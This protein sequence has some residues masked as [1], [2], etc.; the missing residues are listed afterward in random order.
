MPIKTYK[1]ED[2]RRSRR[3]GGYPWTHLYKQPFDEQVDS[4]R[5]KMNALRK[6]KSSSTVERSEGVQ[7]FDVT[8]NGEGEGRMDSLQIVTEPEDISARNSIGSIVIEECDVSDVGEVENQNPEYIALESAESSDNIS[9]YLDKDERGPDKTLEARKLS[10]TDENIEMEKNES[11]NLSP[12]EQSKKKRKMSAES[13]YSRISATKQAVLNKLR[14][15]KNKI[16]VPKFSFPVNKL[17]RPTPKVVKTIPSESKKDVKKQSTKLKYVKPLYI[18]I[19]L[20][21][22]P[23]E[24]DEFSYLEFEDKPPPKGVG[25]FKF[26]AK[27]IKRLQEIVPSEEQVLEEHSSKT[28]KKDNDIIN[29]NDEISKNEV[30]SDENIPRTKETNIENI[31]NTDENKAQKDK[32][33]SNQVES[34]SAVSTTEAEV[35]DE[36]SNSKLEL[37][38][39]ENLNK[40]GILKKSAEVIE[41]S[42]TQPQ[43]S[44]FK[45]KQER[46]RSEEPDRKRKLSLESS[47]SRKSLSKLEIMKKLKET[48]EKIK[49]TFSINRKKKQPSLET[50]TVAKEERPKKAVKSLKSEEQM[51]PVYIHIPLKSPGDEKIPEEE[52]KPSNSPGSPVKNDVQFIILTAPSDDE[53]LDYHSSD[54]PETPSD[55]VTFFDKIDELKKI[56]KDAVNDVTIKLEP[57][58]EETLNGNKPNNDTI[59]DNTPLATVQ[60]FD[61]VTE[62]TPNDD[63]KAEKSSDGDI[64]TRET[65]AGS[66]KT[67]L[68]TTDEIS[69]KANVTID[70]ED[71]L[72]ETLVKEDTQKLPRDEQIDAKDDTRGKS[73]DAN[74]KLENTPTIKKKV[75]FKR[76]SK[77][78]KDSSYEDIEPQGLSKDSGENMEHK[79]VDDISASDLDQL[80][81]ITTSSKEDEDKW[82]KHRY[83]V[84]NHIYLFS[85]TV[86]YWIFS[87]V[88]IYLK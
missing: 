29:D 36:D 10:I 33:F 22:P 40:K 54:A 67:I 60:N 72:S 25:S 51:K 18:Y 66:D 63:I 37:H 17:K 42:S 41:G 7:I 69:D 88:S 62:E 9:Q 83:V 6:S 45:G 8:E 14:D 70:V 34:K 2:V 80:A 5:F 65:Q 59:N 79:N 53:I 74:L 85:A 19:P 1:W 64:K 81:S 4:E 49:K 21:P 31:D 82:S 43:K 61:I 87:L 35:Q 75:S 39:G 13:S 77:T 57:V 86:E 76:R 11:Q 55:S 44:I 84:R 47:Y 32:D 23:G 48:S 30:T 71:G 73:D 27:N 78:P 15:T 3:R 24:T 28:V 16:K 26:L 58:E 20:K 50:V 52:S 12:D 46:A 68:K 56:A 38:T